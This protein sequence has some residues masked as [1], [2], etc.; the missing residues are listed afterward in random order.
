M[1]RSDLSAA[2]QKI[3]LAERR[4]WHSIQSIRDG[5]AFFDADNIMIGANSAYLSIFDDMD[6]IAPGVAY[7]R[8]LQVLTEEGIVDT[9]DL[10]P[11]DWREMMAEVQAVLSLYAPGGTTGI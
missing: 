3:E 6:E 4:L 5:F 9:G 8:I 2:N 7:T 11:A 1:F 10:H